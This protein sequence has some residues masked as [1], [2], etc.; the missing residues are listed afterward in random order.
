[1]SFQARFFPLRS[2]V[3]LLLAVLLAAS[4]ATAAVAVGSAATAGTRVDGV[5]V[6]VGTTL[7]S[8]ARI[9]TGVR[10]AVVHLSNGRTLALDP[11]TTARLES[12]NGLLHLAV[13]AGGVAFATSDG[14]IDSLQASETMVLDQQGEI[15]EGA[16]IETSPPDA[17]ET[18]RLC[19]LEKWSEQLWQTCTADEPGNDDCNWQLLEVA[20]GQVPQYLDI[21]AVFACK[22]RNTLDLDCDCEPEAF[23]W[24][25]VGAGAGAV[26]LYLLIEDDDDPKPASPSVP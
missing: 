4:P 9:E 14:E 10:P 25:A 18:E 1:M 13:E 24:W 17:G 12:S 22:D 26:A 16:R 19:Q 7:L 6:P 2:P 11:H 23:P 8:P 15:Q 21:T 5:A 20:T 3:A